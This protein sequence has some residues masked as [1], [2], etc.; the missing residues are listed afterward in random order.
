MGVSKPMGRVTKKGLETPLIL[1]PP[2][3]GFF[4]TSFATSFTP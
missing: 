1:N 2:F 4:A 3:K